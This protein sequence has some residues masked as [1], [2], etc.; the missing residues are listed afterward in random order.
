M[1]EKSVIAPQHIPTIVA[2]AVMTALAS[3]AYSLFVYDELKDVTV[4]AVELDVRAARRDVELERQIKQLE[5]R[6][7][8][9]E[10]PAGI[11]PDGQRTAAT[12]DTPDIQ[13]ASAGA[14]PE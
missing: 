5:A 14:V 6:L 8:V 4:G 12:L 9:L 1:S 10:A 2:I 7:R 3:F 11:A 13:G